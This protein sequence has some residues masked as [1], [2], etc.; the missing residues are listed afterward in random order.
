[1]YLPVEGFAGNRTMVNEVRYPDDH[2]CECIDLPNERYGRSIELQPGGAFRLET[3]I[4]LFD[5]H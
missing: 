5:N 1:M 4:K 3:K 2:Y